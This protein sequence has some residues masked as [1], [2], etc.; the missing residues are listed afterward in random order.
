VI[1]VDPAYT[2]KCCSQ[3]GAM[4]QDFDLSTRWVECPCGLSM[5]RDHNAA[6]NILNRALIQDRSDGTVT[7]NVVPLHLDSVRVQAQAFVRSPRL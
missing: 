3:C 4:F 2:S 7:G 6:V 5:D 1:A